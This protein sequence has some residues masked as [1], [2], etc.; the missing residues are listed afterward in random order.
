MLTKVRLC[1][2]SSDLQISLNAY[3]LIKNRVTLGGN[4]GNTLDRIA[5]MTS[6]EKKRLMIISIDQQDHEL[7]FGRA[8]MDVFSPFHIE[9]HSIHS[10]LNPSAYGSTEILE[11]NGSAI[12]NTQE[13]PLRSEFY[14]QLVQ[15]KVFMGALHFNQEEKEALRAWLSKLRAEEK[16]NLSSLIAFLHCTDKVSQIS[17]WLNSP[18]SAYL[19]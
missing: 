16:T 14:K 3:S 4:S 15:Q 1:G 17:G 9:V 5:I 11:T 19:K 10:S 12:V 2:F 8:S 6:H 18:L 13:S 7:G